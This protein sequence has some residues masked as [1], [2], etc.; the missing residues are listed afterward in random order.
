MENFCNTFSY[1]Y[2]FVVNGVFA[3]WTGWNECPV[4]SNQNNERYTRRYRS[5][6]TPMYNGTECIGDVNEEMLCG[7][8]SSVVEQCPSM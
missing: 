4:C 3:E 2:Y 5:C 8:S 6:Y 1:Y 7:D